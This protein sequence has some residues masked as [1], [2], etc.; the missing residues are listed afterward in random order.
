MIT[1]SLLLRKYDVMVELR[2][3]M[4]GARREVLCL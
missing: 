2:V 1:V 3:V 4:I